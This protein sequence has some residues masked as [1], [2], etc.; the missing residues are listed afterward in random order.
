[1]EHDPIQFRVEFIIKEGK[2]EDYK[3]LV[4]EM[5]RVV[6]ANEL[7]TI[8]YQFYLDSTET[9]CVVCETYSNS[10]AALTHNISIESKTML[11]KIFSVARIHKFEVYGNPSKKL[12]KVLANFNAQ[13]YNLIAG[14]SR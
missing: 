2:I 14:F 1:M 5:S 7:D 13:T 8:G 6:K 4:Q 9:K 11:S 12:Q 3:K 10:E